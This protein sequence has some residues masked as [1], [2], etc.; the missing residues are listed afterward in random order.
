MSETE[1]TNEAATSEVE[2][3]KAARS[4]ARRATNR[5]ARAT[6]KGKSRTKARRPKASSRRGAK[7]AA[8]SKKPRARAKAKR[9][10]WSDKHAQL[11]VHC[12]FEI[13]K[14][15]DRK[16]TTIAKRMGLKPQALGKGA[17][18]ITKGQVLRAMVEKA[19][20]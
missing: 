18:R 8:R 17:G 16:L 5:Q 15:F 9:E 20:R 11:V 7:A 1:V 14:K 2:P 3:P 12:S 10:K 4:G 19:C 6:A 13:L